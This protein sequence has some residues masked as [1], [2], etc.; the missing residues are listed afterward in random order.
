M[1]EATKP[2]TSSPAQSPRT[3]FYLT[4]EDCS[5][6]R[7]E[8]G[9]AR[10]KTFFCDAKSE[11]IYSSGPGLGP[12]PVFPEQ[13]MPLE[14]KH[15]LTTN[16]SKDQQ[17]YFLRL[18]CDHLHQQIQIL[19]SKQL[20]EL[21]NSNWEQL[22]DKRPVDGALLDCMIALGIQYGHHTGLSSRILAVNGNSSC[23]GPRPGWSYIRRCR[24][25]LAGWSRVSLE[26][27]QCD[28]LIAL[29]LMHASSYQEAYRVL[30]C[31]VRN[32]L[33]LNLQC[34]PAE[35]FST[36][37]KTLRKRL[38]WLLFVMDFQ[39]SRQLGKPLAVQLSIITCSL[40]VSDD[41]ETKSAT[42]DEDDITYLAFLTHMTKLAIIWTDIQQRLSMN[43]VY[44]G[45]CNAIV[46]EHCADRISA[47]LL[48]L[49]TWMSEI[50]GRFTPPSG[51]S[52]AQT[53][54]EK[55]GFAFEL[56][57]P[58]RIQ[59]QRIILILWYHDTYIMLQR[60][61]ICFATPGQA[62]AQY[63]SQSALQHSLVVISIV[64]QAFSSSD[65]LYGWPEAIYILWNA[66]TAVL[67][68][69]R[70]SPE[71]S[72]VPSAI[73]SIRKALWVFENY[74]V[75]CASSVMAKNVIQSLLSK[76]NVSMVNLDET[77]MDAEVRTATSKTSQ[78]L[79]LRDSSSPLLTT[80][81]SSHDAMEIIGLDDLVGIENGNW[82]LSWPT[83]EV[84]QGA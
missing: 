22:Y 33:S 52:M 51:Y 40:P 8:G 83:Y 7:D 42:V 73:A 11:S 54:I 38:W 46:L 39:C 63:H 34:D 48:Q 44:E 77:G 2:P 70:V 20:K 64:H 31:A 10:L 60:P 13:P 30:G 1:K 12:F 16:L 57:V 68:F 21:Y 67:G 15:T 27:L 82:D 79:G 36:V 69:I 66:T 58:P 32:A 43:K 45:T 3:E 24:K 4:Y 18:F 19:T 41:R 76:L 53:N 55:H 71:R 78:Q 65:I 72:R 56:G 47:S 35:H 50:S 59:R 49:D 17:S 9:L 28:L 6:S 81:S 25:I 74:S 84:L 23:D 14:D 5:I 62:K 26:V 37:E 61:F 75:T 29:F 80:L